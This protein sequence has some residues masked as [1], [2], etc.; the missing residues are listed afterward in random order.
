MDRAVAED[1]ADL[2]RHLGQF[3][4]GIPTPHFSPNSSGSILMKIRILCLFPF[5]F[6]PKCL[7]GEIRENGV[8]PSQTRRVL[9][10]SMQRL[11]SCRSIG[12]NTAS[13]GLEPRVEGPTIKCCACIYNALKNIP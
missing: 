6:L 5:F 13:E 9:M 4:F 8:P 11:N 12:N 2:G 10:G 7:C 3:E 1:C